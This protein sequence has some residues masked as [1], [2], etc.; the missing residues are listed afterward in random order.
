MNI[1]VA[2]SL[3]VTFLQA[4]HPI[5]AYQLTHL[6]SNDS[7]DMIIVKLMRPSRTGFASK[8]RGLKLQCGCLS[9]EQLRKQ[10][11]TTAS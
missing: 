9:S 4:H 10:R 1:K 5:V 8:G 6:V 7:N 2:A 11:A 3:K